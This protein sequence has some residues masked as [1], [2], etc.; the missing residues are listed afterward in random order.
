[1]AAPIFPASPKSLPTTGGFSAVACG[2]A[3]GGVCAPAGNASRRG[4]TTKAIANITPVTHL[5]RL[6]I[7]DLLK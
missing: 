6:F 4:E 3:L 7:T 2:G 1:M 5:N